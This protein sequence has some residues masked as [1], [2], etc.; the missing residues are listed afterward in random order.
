MKKI[1]FAFFT[2]FFSF[3]LFA[4]ESIKGSFTCETGLMNG[5][6]Q[7]YVYYIAGKDDLRK[8]SEL[9]W[10]VYRIPYTGLKMGLETNSGI[11]VNFG[12]RVGI[13]KASGVMQ[14]FDWMNVYAHM[15]DNW[16]TNYSIHYNILDSFS[17]V[18]ASADWKFNVIA[19]FYVRP[20]LFADI[21]NISFYSKDGY[22]FYGDELSDSTD[23][24][25]HYKPY[26]SET[27]EERRL[28]KG[29]VISYTQKRIQSGAG[30]TLGYAFSNYEL[31]VRGAL[32]YANILAED[33]HLL[34]NLKFA[35][36]PVGFGG[37]KIEGNFLW[38]INKLCGIGVSANCDIQPLLIGNDYW[39]PEKSETWFLDSEDYGGTSWSV[40]S[41]GVNYTVKF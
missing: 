32:R 26:S 9:D 6:I 4:E 27:K 12:F 15:E 41:L 38:N 19:G 36:L 29:K 14:D 10:D 34:R 35:D 39:A 37:Y 17:N 23:E 28:F 16:I 7:E 22:G 13:P 31:N 24:K 3:G 8:L 11:S 2:L 21:E 18:Y 1:F 30:L 20:D 40:F 5:Q 33:H 25:L